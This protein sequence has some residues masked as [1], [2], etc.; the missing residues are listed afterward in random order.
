LTFYGFSY[1]FFKL[2]TM[3][4]IDDYDYHLP[5][6]LIAQAPLAERDQAR[7]LV[8]NRSAGSMEHS[9]F[10]CLS[11]WLSHQDVLVVNNTRVFPARLRGHKANGGKV[12]AL[13]LAPPRMRENGGLPCLAE[14]RALFRAS[15]PPKIGQQLIFGAEL[16]G[17]ITAVAPSG[18][19]GLVLRSSE[20]DLGQI[21]AESGD[22]PL[23]PYIRRPVEPED[24]QRYQTVFAAQT[25][26]VAAPTAGLHFTPRVLLELGARGVE[27]IH[28]TLHVGPGTF[29]PVREADYSRHRLA[30][31]PFTLSEASAAAINRARAAGKR[32]VA[33]G[34]TSVRVLEAQYRH[35]QVQSGAGDCGLFIYPGYQFKVVDR[36][37]TNFHL[38]KSTLLLLVSALA[39][40]ELVLQAYQS[41][42]AAGYR[43]YSYGD[44]MLIL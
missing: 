26:A 12:E 32:I 11:Q 20:R 6:E 28:L 35:G 9:R 33:V 22:M 34:T 19:I 42:M 3:L 41:A 30:P 8:L 24:R 21:L 39:G 18:E 13:L 2:I 14:G 44:C 10:A 29:Q 17:E 37:I 38:P 25:G 15:K 36:L 16:T 5:A 27:V 31:E 23:P 43:F 40:R 4:S 7:M 1:Y